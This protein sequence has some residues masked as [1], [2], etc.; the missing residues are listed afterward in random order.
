MDS[1]TQDYPL[2][3]CS[4]LFKSLMMVRDSWIVKTWSFLADL[5]SVLKVFFWTLFLPFR[6]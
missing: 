4:V 3:F 2:M 5:N 1:I 6:L